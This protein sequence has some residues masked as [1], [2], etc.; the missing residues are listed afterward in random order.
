MAKFLSAPEEA[1]GY[2]LSADNPDRQN[3]LRAAI[4]MSRIYAYL[5]AAR[6]QVRLIE[7]YEKKIVPKKASYSANMIQ[8]FIHVHLYFICWAAIGRMVEV[9][10]QWSGLKAPNDMWKKYRK[11]VESYAGVTCPGKFGPV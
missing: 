9:I 3:T 11:V 6:H 7:T 1:M 2:L 10:R 8:A 4:A 5:Q